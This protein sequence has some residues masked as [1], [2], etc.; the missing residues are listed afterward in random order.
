MILIDNKNNLTIPGYNHNFTYKMDFTVRIEDDSIATML[1]G[2]GEH[3]KV[4]TS[5]LEIL[6]G[7]KEI[8]VIINKD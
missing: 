5:T 8:R 6:N 3:S 4:F 1:K 2:A 7:G